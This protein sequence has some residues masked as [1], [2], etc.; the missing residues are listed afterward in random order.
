MVEDLTKWPKCKSDNGIVA[1]V[2]VFVYIS[3]YFFNIVSC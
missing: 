3:V 2:T 1:N